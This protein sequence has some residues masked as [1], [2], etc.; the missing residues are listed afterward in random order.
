M[1]ALVLPKSRA[2]ARK[3]KSDARKRIKVT[4]A[5]TV[6]QNT[7][8]KGTNLDSKYE[9]H[10]RLKKNKCHAQHRRLTGELLT[11]KRLQSLRVIVSAYCIAVKIFVISGCPFTSTFTNTGT[12]KKKEGKEKERTNIVNHIEFSGILL[13]FAVIHRWCSACHARS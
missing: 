13:F 6:R 2:Y 7:E 4:E 3:Q 10:C 8:K 5:H 11:P 12:Q 9:K 1:N